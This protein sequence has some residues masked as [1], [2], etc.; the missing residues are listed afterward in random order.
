M[1]GEQQTLHEASVNAAKKIE[2]SFTFP[3][4]N[5]SLSRLRVSRREKLELHSQQKSAANNDRGR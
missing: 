4:F 2:K 5:F 1:L 3:S